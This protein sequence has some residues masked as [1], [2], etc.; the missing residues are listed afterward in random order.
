MGKHYEVDADTGKEKGGTFCITFRRAD[1]IGPYAEWIFSEITVPAHWKISIWQVNIVQR[2]PGASLAFGARE[3]DSGVVW[4]ST[5]LGSAPGYFVEG[6]PLGWS[7]K[8]KQ[9]ICQLGVFSFKMQKR[10]ERERGGGLL[11]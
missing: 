2:S 10:L 8:K 3:R 4:Y 11:L 5:E 9:W 6:D 7:R 1:S